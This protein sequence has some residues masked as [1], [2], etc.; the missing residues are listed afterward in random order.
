MDKKEYNSTLRE[1]SE[2]QIGLEM[3]NHIQKC[4]ICNKLLMDTNQKI[5][6]HIRE[7]W[8]K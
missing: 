6:N 7:T 5:M 1:I 2:T 8:N 3:V 4:S